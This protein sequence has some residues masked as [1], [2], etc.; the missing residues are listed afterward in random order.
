MRKNHLYCLAVNLFALLLLSGTCLGQEVIQTQMAMKGAEVDLVQAKIN[1][2]VLSVAFSVRAPTDDTISQ[3]EIKPEEVFYVDATQ[4][5]KY[6]ILKDEK[7]KWLA[8]PISKLVGPKDEYLIDIKYVKKGK[9]A[10]MWMKFP[11]PQVDNAK[12]EINLP[13]IVPFSDIEIGTPAQ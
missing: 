13:G 12:I 7:G 10:I 4:N 1:G 6:H 5:K 2:K 8:G 3:F 9:S 11:A